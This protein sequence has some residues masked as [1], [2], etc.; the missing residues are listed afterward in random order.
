MKSKTR[1]RKTKVN[2]HSERED[3]GACKFIYLYSLVIAFYV[4]QES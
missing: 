3:D 4:N 2:R 1:E